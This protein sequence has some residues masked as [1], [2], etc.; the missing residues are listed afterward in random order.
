M[1]RIF[2]IETSSCLDTIS[3][4]DNDKSLFVKQFRE[5]FDWIFCYHATRLSNNEVNNIKDHGLITSNEELLY[6]KAIARFV[7]D[8][9]SKD[10]KERITKCIDSYYSKNGNEI[11]K[12]INLALSKKNLEDSAYQY[13]YYGPESLLPLADQLTKVIKGIYFR[14]RLINFGKPYFVK[15]LVPVKQV[16]Y[17]WIENIWNYSECTLKEILEE[18]M[19][20]SL[21]MYDSIPAVQILEIEEYKKIIT[22]KYGFR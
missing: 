4:F 2:K 6:T 15:L 22:N 5:N 13:L 3:N 18:N 9:D 19:D 17:I 1:K 14:S 11:I 7:L 21:V 10:L 8:E 12:E 20:I 16:E